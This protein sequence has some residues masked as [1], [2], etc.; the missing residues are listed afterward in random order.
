M[1]RIQI[2]G[3]TIETEGPTSV[4]VCNGRVFVDGKQITKIGSAC[5]KVII[6]G[7]VGDIKADG[8]VEVDGNVNGD[9][10][11]GGHVSCGDVSGSIDAGGHVTAK[12][13]K[14]NVDAGGHVRIGR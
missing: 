13:V 9:I 6:K 5:T 8:S 2:N 14:Q 10:D 11:A 1:N 4:S 12:N 3:L 7:N